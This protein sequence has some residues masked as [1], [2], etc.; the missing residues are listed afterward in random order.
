MNADC[1][2]AAVEL[3]QVV[4]V[5]PNVVDVEMVFS[6]NPVLIQENMMKSLQHFQID[7][8]IASR[9]TKLINFIDRS[10][11]QTIF[12]IVDPETAHFVVIFAPGKFRKGK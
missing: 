8:W 3:N 12:G 2:C 10:F 7:V 5:E 1:E 6:N 4:Y 11:M 9:W